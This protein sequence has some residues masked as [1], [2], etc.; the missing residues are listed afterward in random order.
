MEKYARRCGLDIYNGNKNEFNIF[1]INF[2]EKAIDECPISYSIKS[3]GAEYINDAMSCYQ[4]Y[5]SGFLP[6]V[7]DTQLNRP[8]SILD[9]TEFF[10]KSYNM[11]SKVKNKAEKVALN[12][13]K[14]GK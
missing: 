10:H 12:A 5:E 8:A 2:G 3:G 4:Y 14:K 9:Q 6:E 7:W 11:V 13:T 1:K